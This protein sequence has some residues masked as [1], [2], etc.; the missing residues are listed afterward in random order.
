MESGAVI[1][2]AAMIDGLV[3]RI[4]QELGKPV[5]LVLTGEWP[6]MPNPSAPIHISM[7]RSCWQRA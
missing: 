7:T 1:G 3:A 6:A 4:E 5:T 2:A